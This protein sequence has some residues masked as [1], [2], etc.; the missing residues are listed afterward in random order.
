MQLG[1]ETMKMARIA[2]LESADATEA[3]TSA[4]RGF[5][6][7]LNKASAERINDVY[8]QLAATSASNV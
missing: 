5:N 1:I 2:G 3:M 8:S 7:E 4:L 6:M